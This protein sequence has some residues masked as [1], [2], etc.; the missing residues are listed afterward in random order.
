[1]P[2]LISDDAFEDDPR[3]KAAADYFLDVDTQLRPVIS[4]LNGFKVQPGSAFAGDDEATRTG[5]ISHQASAL[6]SVAADNAHALRSVVVKAK[7]IPAFAGCSLTRN[8]IERAGVT[9]WL[10]GPPT[11][12]TRVLHA[13]Q[14]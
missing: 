11:R 1:M 13:L 6:L 8:A 12:D 9:L 5:A 2:P 14:L 3:N 4:R 7:V 10:M